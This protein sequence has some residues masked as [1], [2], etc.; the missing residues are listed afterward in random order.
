[1]LAQVG[2]AF[3][4]ILCYNRFVFC[5]GGKRLAQENGSYP[6]PRTKARALCG[7]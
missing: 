7:R 4:L 2:M 5:F 1:M 3:L 6:V